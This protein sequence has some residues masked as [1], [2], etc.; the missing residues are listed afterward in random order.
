MA[1]VEG[2]CRRYSL[3]D[4]LQFSSWEHAEV[5]ST[6]E[7]EALGLVGGSKVR[8]RGMSAEPV[9]PVKEPFGSHAQLHF[10]FTKDFPGGSVVRS[11]PEMQET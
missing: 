5:L 7:T 10:F 2:V 4:L 8:P 3:P 1:A 11:L 6:K 9:E